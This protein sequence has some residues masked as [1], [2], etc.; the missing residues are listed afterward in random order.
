M[1][2][3]EQKFFKDDKNCFK[4]F[5]IRRKEE[6]ECLKVVGEGVIEDVKSEQEDESE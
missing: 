2:F 5:I 1:F 6:E 4:I 3:R